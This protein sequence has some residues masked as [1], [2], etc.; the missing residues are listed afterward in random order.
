MERL[1]DYRLDDVAGEELAAK[2]E[3]AQDDI[4]TDLLNGKRW[5]E[6]SDY[7][8]D[9]HPDWLNHVLLSKVTYKMVVLEIIRMEQ[10]SLLADL[11]EIIAEKERG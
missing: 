10:P 11:A 1:A 2:Q 7:I 9:F 8:Y 4:M 5:E 3:Q 6:L